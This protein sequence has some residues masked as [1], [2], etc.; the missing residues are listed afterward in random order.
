MLK[1][2]FIPFRV[3]GGFLAGKIATGLFRR[4]WALIDSEQAPDPEQRDASLGKLVA[5]LALQGA[6]FQ[7]VRGLTD[8]GS[9][10][11]FSRLTGRWPG[12]QHAKPTDEKD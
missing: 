8:H 11:A 10:V 6:V 7:G 1:L 5:G 9:R 3:I 2:M 12:K 4:L